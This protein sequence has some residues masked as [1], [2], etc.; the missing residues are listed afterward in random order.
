[1]GLSSRTRKSPVNIMKTHSF[2][3]RG[4]LLTLVALTSAAGLG[5][6]AGCSKHDRDKATDTMQT[7]ADNTKEA[8]SSAWD[9]AKSYTFG[10]R[11]QFTANAKALQ[12]KMDAQ[13]SEVQANVADANASASRQAAWQE[14]KDA[15]ANYKEKVSALGDA[16]ADTWDS[17]KENTIAAWDRLQAAY[18]KARAD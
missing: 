8:F 5:A 13:V 12:S 18:Y 9:K 2:R 17:A 1:M 11:D 3:S 15:D 10:E 4:S 6:L 14:L 16:T 7:A